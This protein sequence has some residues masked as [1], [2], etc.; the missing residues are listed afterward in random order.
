MQKVYDETLGGQLHVIGCGAF[1][2]EALVSSIPIKR[3]EDMK[4]VKI[5]SPE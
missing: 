5:R 4:G 3:L 1:S 2:R